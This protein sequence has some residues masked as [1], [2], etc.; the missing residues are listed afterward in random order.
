MGDVRGTSGGMAVKPSPPPPLHFREGFMPRNYFCDRCNDRGHVGFFNPFGWLAGEFRWT[1]LEFLIRRE[2]PKC[3][4][5]P[6]SLMPPQS[7]L[8]PHP[9]STVLF[10][11]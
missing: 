7:L 10:R 11:G 3:L 5:D 9:P 1:F 4:G 2:C 6:N 8:K